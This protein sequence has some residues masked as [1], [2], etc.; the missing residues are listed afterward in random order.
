MLDWIRG[1][2]GHVLKKKL[3]YAVSWPR[4]LLLE[5]GVPCDDEVTRPLF[6]EPIHVY[7]I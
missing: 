6:S 4:V 7:L 1:G 2:W 3:M 5:L